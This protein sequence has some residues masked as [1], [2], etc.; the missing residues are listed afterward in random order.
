M[1]RPVLVGKKVCLRELKASDATSISKNMNDPQVTK[2]VGW[3]YPFTMHDASALIQKYRKGMQNGTCYAL[4]IEEKGKN[5]VIGTV[6]FVL[7]D[8]QRM[9]ALDFWL[10]RRFWRRGYTEEAVRLMIKFGFKKLKLRRIYSA[11]FQRNKASNGLLLKVGFSEYR[12]RFTKL[13]GRRIKQIRYAMG[14][15]I[16]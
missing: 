8:E 15:G 5:T 1:N 16:K 2:Y 12:R 13:K 7:M 14:E 11:A 9:P 3:R 4:G 6:A 10:G